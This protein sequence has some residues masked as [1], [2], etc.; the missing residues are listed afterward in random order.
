MGRRVEQTP[1][2]CIC[3]ERLNIKAVTGACKL[4]AGCNL[5]LFSATVS[6]VSAGI[7]A[8]EI[9]SIQLHDFVVMASPCD[10]ISY[11]TLHLFFARLGF[12]KVWCRGG[13]GEGI[14]VFIEEVMMRGHLAQLGENKAPGTDGM[15]K[16]MEGGIDTPLVLKFQRLSET[17]QVPEQW[18]EAN[19][20]AIYTN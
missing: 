8:T 13:G 14:G 19:F 3:T 11:V 20:T 17:G 10:G 15:V 4:I 5:A 1:K 2:C 9:K 12:L 16:N 18:K 7:Y 6:V